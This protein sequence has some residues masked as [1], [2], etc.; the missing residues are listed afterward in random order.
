MGFYYKSRH[1]MLRKSQMYNSFAE[2][3]KILKQKCLFNIQPI[4]LAAA[5]F[6]LAVAPDSLINSNFLCKVDY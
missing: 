1:D 5:A 6:T 2:L 4:C 3:K